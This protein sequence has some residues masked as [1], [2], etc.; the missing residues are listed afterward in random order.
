MARSNVAQNGTKP[1][2]RLS[3]WGALFALFM[4]PLIATPLSPEVT[5]DL[6]DF[7]VFALMLFAL[8]CAVELAVA[9]IRVGWMRQL[10]LVGAV[11]G[12]LLVWA[13]LAVGIV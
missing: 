10:A 12:F 13:Q 8:G 2:A 4:V 7:V 1:A 5:W 6:A 11:L 9:T 3:G